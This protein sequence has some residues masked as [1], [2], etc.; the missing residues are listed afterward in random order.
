MIETSMTA[1]NPALPPVPVIP[2]S[3]SQGEDRSAFLRSLITRLGGEP[4][5]IDQDQS[6]LSER[7]ARTGAQ[8]MV[9]DGFLV[10]L[11]AEAR[12]NAAPEG[13]FAPGVG[14]KRFGSMLDQATADRMLESRNF[15]M[16]D[17]LVDRLRSSFQ[18]VAGLQTPT[19]EVKS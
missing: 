7:L 19:V 4:G 3:P 16:V 8:R 13:M 5:P 9:A 15:P 11:L 18:R 2:E 10:P 14:E 17:A 6:Q 1:N 12:E